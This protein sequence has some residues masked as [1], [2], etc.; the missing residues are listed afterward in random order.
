MGIDAMFICFLEDEERNENRT[1]K[2]P[3]E[4]VDYVEQTEK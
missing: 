4:M 3:Q 1:K 2:A